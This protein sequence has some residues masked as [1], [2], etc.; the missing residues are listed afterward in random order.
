MFGYM[1][2]TS[3]IRV[4]RYLISAAIGLGRRALLVL[5][6]AAGQAAFLPEAFAQTTPN[7]SRWYRGSVDFWDVFT[8]QLVATSVQQTFSF[9][10]RGVGTEDWETAGIYACTRTSVTPASQTVT[11]STLPSECRRIRDPAAIN[12]NVGRFDVNVTPSAAEITNGGVVIVYGLR[13]GS[14]ANYTWDFYY[15]EW[16]PL[17]TPP[18]LALAP[19]TIA[20]N[21]G[22]S[23]VTA[24]L[25]STVSTAV[26]VTVTPV[27]GAYT[28]TSDATIVIAAGSTANAADSVTIRAVDNATDAPDRM[29]SVTG[30]ASSTY[31]IAVTPAELTLTDDDAAPGVTLALAPTSMTENG[32]TTTVTAALTHPS[33]AAT[34]VTLAA[35]AGAYTV[36]A[37][38]TIV[39]A[40]GDTANAADT[41]VLTGED[42]TTDAPDRTV[43]VLAEAANA[44]G[45]GTVTGAELTLT[46]DDAAPGATLTLMPA[47]IAESGG[48]A[49]V[50][51]TLTHPS[52]LVSEVTVTPAAGFYTVGADAM[53]EIAAGATANA[54]DT[55]TIAAVDDAADT[56]ADRTVTVTG[57]L[58]NRQGAGAV[59]GA[60]LT[61]T[62]D[63]TRGVTL[64]GATL[65]VLENETATY[66]V[67][68]DTQPVG[69]AVTVTATSA[70]TAVAT[71]ASPAVVFTAGNWA[72]AQAVTVAG[73]DDQAVT[74]DRTV[75]VTHAVDGADYAGETVGAVTVTVTDDEVAGLRVSPTR[76]TVREQGAVAAY[77]LRLTTQPAGE[78]VTV[79]VGETPTGKLEVDADPNTPGVQSLLTFTD[80]TWDTP[81]RVEVRGL[82]DADGV[83][84]TVTLTHLVGAGPGDY[85]GGLTATTRPSVQVTVEDNDVAGV[86]VSAETL[87]LTEDD[88]TESSLT[89]TV[90]LEAAP[91]AGVTVTLTTRPAGAVTVAPGALTFDAT[92]WDTAQTVTASAVSD[93]D[94]AGAEV[95][96]THALTGAEEY[97]GGV[98]V[99]AVTV[100]DVRVT[101][102]DDEKQAVWVDGMSATRAVTVAEG[103]A[104]T[105]PVTLG[106]APTAPVVVRIGSDNPEVYARPGVLRF[107][108]STWDT[109]QMVTVR[110]DPDADARADAA[111]LR[112]TAAGGDY[113]G[114]TAAVT[115]TV[116]DDDAA[117]EIS[118]QAVSML[119]G[120]TNTYTVTL[121]AEPAGTVT[122]GVA[123]GAVAQATVAP[124]ALV[125][126]PATW[127]T[128]QTVTVTGAGAGS[129]TLSHTVA[130]YGA[131]TTATNVAVTV[132]PT[133]ERLVVDPRFMEV[134]EGTHVTYTI[135]LATQP[136]AGVTWEVRQQPSV[137]VGAGA[138][139]NN[140]DRPNGV[141][142]TFDENNWATPQ[143]F[144]IANPNRTNNCG[145]GHRKQI[146]HRIRP[147]GGSTIGD[148]FAPIVLRKLLNTVPILSAVANQ[149][150]RMGQEMNVRLGAG[151]EQVRAGP[152]GPGGI[153]RALHNAAGI[154]TGSSTQTYVNGPLTY[155]L[156]GPET[157][158]PA[159][160]ATTLTL[161][162]GL[163]FDAAARSLR[164]RPTQAL[165]ATTYR[166][167]VADAQGDTNEL[168]GSAAVRL[169]TLTV[170]AAP[171]PGFARQEPP[172]RH[173]LG[174]PVTPPQV[175]PRPDVAA[176]TTPVLTFVVAPRL[177]EGLTYVPP[178]RSAAGTY[179]DGGRIVGTP[180]R[181][182][183]SREYTL[184]VVDGDGSVAET[185]FA[186]ATGTAAPAPPPDPGPDPA[187]EDR[188]PTF[189]AVTVPAQVYRQG[190]AIAPL[191]LPAATDGDGPLGYALT[192]A[193]P[194]GLTYTAPADATS[195]GT[196]AGVPAAA[197]AA[198]TYTLTATDADGDVATL[199][200]TLA[201]EAASG[202]ILAR[203]GTRTVT[204]YGHQVTV[205]QTPGTV[206][207]VELML[208]ATLAQAVTITLAPPGA[209]V[210]L[211]RDRY[212]F[213]P[214]GARAAVDVGVAPVPAGGMEL[215][216]PVPAGLRL[217][218]GA[219]EL[220]LLRYAGEEWAPVT[221]AAD[222]AGAG[223]ICAVGV[224]AFG[225]LAVGYENAVPRFTEPVAAQTFLVNEARSEPLPAAR[226]GD[227]PLRYTL[228]PAAL[229][230]G[231]RYTPPADPTATGGVIAGTPTEGRPPAPYTLTATDAD[232]D[233]DM[234][235][236][237]IEVVRIPVQVTIGDALAVEGAPVE[238]TV[239]L[240]RAVARA[241]TL[242]WTAG[243]PGSATPGA[244]YPAEAAGR[245]VLAA[246]T[247]AGTL[248]VPTLDDRRVE[249]TETF[250]VT[251]TLPADPLFESADATATGRIEDDDTE[252][253]RRRSLGMV[254]AGVGRTLAT[255]AVD[256]IGDRFVRP[257]TN[258]QVTVGGQA[259]SL[260]RAPQTGRWRQAAGVTY[261]VAR[262]LGVEVGVPLA[263]GDGPFGQVRGA[264]WHT[265]TRH[266]RE[267]HAAAA[268]LSAWDAPSAFPAPA[269]TDP[270]GPLP[271][272]WGALGHAGAGN[273]IP[274]PPGRGADATP[275]GRGAFPGL[276]G[277]GTGLGQG[278]FDRAHAAT[279]QA[280]KVG[281]FRAPVQ[282]RRVSGAEVLSQSEFELPLR[283][284]APAT[285][286]PTPVGVTEADP[287][288]P[289]PPVETAP[290]AAAAAWTLWGRGTASGFDGR[291]KDDFSMDGN[292]FTGYLGL[293]YRL[294]PN[295]LLGLA[296][297]HS[298]GDVDY[299][300][301]DVTKGDVD[302]T[303]TS[304]LPYAHWSP[305]P[306]LGVW[307]LFGAGWGDLQLR[308]EAGKVKTDLE[309]LMAAVGARQ[310]VLTWRRI[311]VA[312][313]ADAFLTELEA[314][315]DDRLPK[316]AGDAQRLRLMVEGRTAWALSEDAR[317]TP[318]FEIGGRWDG[319]K[320]ETGVGAELGGGVEYAHTK[321]GLG[322]EA[323]GRYLL[324][325]QKS[326]FDEWG[327]SL[328]LKLDPGEAQRG[329]WLAVA[330]VWG[331][332]ASQVEQMWGSAEV[333]QA[334]A[335]SATPGLSP[336]QVE[337]DVGYGLVTYEGAG[338]LTTY[339]GVS[340]AG[341]DSQ[342]YRL[343][344]RIELGEWIDL[345]VEGERTTQGSGA[346]HQVAL[347]GHLGW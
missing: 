67:V 267:P 279:P 101:V 41:V 193:L 112:H 126:N 177:P 113:T 172:V 289:T 182:T 90:V 32:G 216:L 75:Q 148:T 169:F 347:Y 290:Q 24:T 77:T 3:S 47:T 143:V 286:A 110:A 222:D 202:V 149:T 273:S 91:T 152:H 306:G 225:P 150:G 35:A 128:A 189:G 167:R 42:N 66:T 217:E 160:P 30:T 209:D 45:I 208:P 324:A 5:L 6:L 22:L 59:T 287:A 344:G 109:A 130:G 50:T 89:Y 158:Y 210:P 142:R 321:L 264:A 61:L 207:G 154:Q 159:N 294:Q 65:R 196:L 249:P 98:G 203:D 165:P 84:V 304:V 8:A 49:T 320:A 296:V 292:V 122:V 313:K 155:T 270:G 332:E 337:F 43:T 252:R 117:V 339:G 175:L 212:G 52:S 281:T 100:A 20:E 205:T 186:L 157:D 31:M 114:T 346:A 277:Y 253:A 94:A 72:T 2:Q 341:P 334:G 28:V 283:Q 138:N 250:T 40:A 164:G 224:T 223:R 64:S 258:R 265:L 244:D 259:L 261:G 272:G 214:A 12:P 197:Q 269:G 82:D 235:T 229:P 104:A 119:E 147:P 11:E 133:T 136:A 316:T 78:T 4:R 62:D 1:S 234:V 305:R 192:P 17:V 34:T 211:E 48:V 76:L 51:A 123:S 88:A 129:A 33:S 194:A 239:T 318:I 58:A 163:R 118:R 307:G 103:G 331:A 282:F 238:F 278:G 190:E 85:A 56:A 131:V 53:I 99:P 181:A 137:S 73:A 14:S 314:G 215:C 254:L 246:G 187:L 317:L 233:A 97:A 242:R 329:L 243:R 288:A 227:G 221:G 195:G 340:M 57:T 200:F 263:G 124:A 55:V 81:Q 185:T 54:A 173:P 39:I 232:G 300:T 274:L 213:G 121:E 178:P 139:C 220:R 141:Y 191:G 271:T 295:V 153:N 260:H 262:A 13:S 188:Q 37:D 335:E 162:A 301:R 44:Q 315:A 140:M 135:R 174:R 95:T 206:A 336:A 25:A 179:A 10:R 102:V 120:E 105:Y 312:L 86:A 198:T 309:M 87:E 319:G 125:F 323:R 132:V 251:G 183:S 228:T 166:L 345:S 218:A 7:P 146:P 343:G 46:D 69:G 338:L 96:V 237:T 256:V 311:D 240:S 231:L 21:G 36:G 303:L 60:E 201:V 255:D 204:V 144:G 16:L 293:D 257:P 68:L 170:E 280:M 27:A 275:F 248:R 308:D 266:L 330:P 342:G 19:A 219:R 74:N 171:L 299:E 115:V 199:T 134:L 168:E 328:T 9:G 156:T 325:H 291:P 127:A 63:D 18:T 161:P 333:L 26:T 284:P 38:T 108:A 80:A 276:A 327:A 93:A 111:T 297:A 92:T 310:E 230:A 116:T 106:S 247:T 298:Q 79:A 184:T 302:L 322:I 83:D 70:D 29:V 176:G 107:D 245:L 268:P 71:V 326:A 15:A 236:F 151:V 285:D 241:L 226:G 180:T 23:T 145:A